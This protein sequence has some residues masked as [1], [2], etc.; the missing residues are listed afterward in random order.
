MDKIS[1]LLEITIVRGAFDLHLIPNAP[2]TLRVIGVLTPV[3]NRQALTPKDTK[4]LIF[5]LLDEEQKEVLTV[6]KEIDFAFDYQGKARFRVNAYYQRGSLAAALRL[7]PIKIPTIDELS[8]PN[9]CQEFVKLHQGFVLLTGPTSHGKSTTIAAILEEINRTR[10]IHI[11]TIEDPIE[12]VFTH[13]K[14]LVSQREIK[15]DTHSWQIALRSCL[16]EDPDVVFVGEMRDYETIASALTIAETGHLVFSTLHT[17]S[18]AQSVDRIVDVFPEHQQGQ[19]RMQ[20]SMSLEAVLSERLM[21]C[22]DGGVV[23]AM[24]VLIGTPSVKTAIREGKT[25]LIDNI[26]QTSA[27]VG[28]M[29]LEM[30]MSRLV[31]QGKISLDVAKTYSLRPEELM[32]LVKR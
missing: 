12:Y 30:E 20:L 17:N 2:P 1:E 10:P 22:L 3:P 27:E 7:L 13:K 9:I 25:H 24:E 31:K 16:R 8:L 28:M 11:I 26:I 18:A 19:V 21:P 23:P 5:S 15:S 14:A 29:S 6:N 4:E 32:R